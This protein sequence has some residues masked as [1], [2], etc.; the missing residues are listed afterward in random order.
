MATGSDDKV[1]YRQSHLRGLVNTAGFAINPCKKREVNMSRYQARTGELKL[2]RENISGHCHRV[3]LFLR[4]LGLPYETVDIDLHNGEARTAQFKLLNPLMQVPVLIHGPRAICD[5]NAILSYLTLEFEAWNWW[6][7]DP[8]FH[9]Q[10]Q[11]WLSIAA[12]E[13]L[14]GPVTA[15]RIVVYNR[16]FDQARAIAASTRFLS[17]LDD[18]LYQ[19]AYLV[20]GVPTV[21]DIAIYT[22]TAHAPEGGISLLPYP[23]IRAWLLR[24]EAWPAFVSMPQSAVP[25]PLNL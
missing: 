19:K 17:F 7:N 14:I 13:L 25:A 18:H 2:L 9:S 21:A 24:I 10:I 20:N 4:V 6:P 5:S 23:S 1:R 16:D 12:G 15:R 22:Y 8:F 3:E 11:R